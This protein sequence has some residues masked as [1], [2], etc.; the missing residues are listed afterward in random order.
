M[1]SLRCTAAGECAS[2]VC[3]TQLT[4]ER[5]R[6]AP[7]EL[8][9]PLCFWLSQHCSVNYTSTAAWLCK[10]VGADSDGSV[11]APGAHLLVALAPCSNCSVS[12]FLP[13]PPCH[14]QAQ[15]KA[16]QIR[17][18]TYFCFINTCMFTFV[19]LLF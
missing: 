4:A 2:W 15:H 1:A 8:A 13:F 11:C 6:R 5:C 12:S 16:E 9:F 18:C 19:S 10:N 17:C 3:S 7:L 14:A